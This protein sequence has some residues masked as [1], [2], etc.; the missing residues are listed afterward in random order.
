MWRK[1]RGV[2]LPLFLRKSLFYRRA[3]GFVCHT[4]PYFIACFGAIQ[5]FFANMRDG[6]C[7]TCFQLS[8]EEV[9]QIQPMRNIFG[10]IHLRANTCGACIRTRANTGNILRSYAGTILGGNS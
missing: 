7:Q 8:A 9:L 4:T 10:G 3:K 6:G 1:R 5:V 2:R